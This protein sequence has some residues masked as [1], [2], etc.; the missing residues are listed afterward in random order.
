MVD[1]GVND[2]VLAGVNLSR[3]RIIFFKHNDMADLERILREVVATDRRRGLDGTHQ[4]RYIVVEGIYRNY[5]DVCPIAAVVQLKR[6]FKFRIVLDECISFGVLGS[7]GRGVT[8]HAGVSFRD[9]DIFLGAMNSSLA[10]VGGFCAGMREVVD[11]QRLSGAGYCFSAA[12]PPFTAAA[13]DEA[14]KIMEV[15]R[16]LRPPP[17]VVLDRC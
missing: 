7:G 10:S 14:L 5:G 1:E 4:R 13:A 9:A 11:H 15:G 12:A 3:A 8:E 2:A 16:A 17:T 6:Q